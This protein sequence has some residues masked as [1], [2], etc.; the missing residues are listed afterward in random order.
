MTT[1]IKNQTFIIV[2]QTVLRGFRQCSCS[3]CEENTVMPLQQPVLV[4]VQNCT[5]GCMHPFPLPYVRLCL[6]IRLD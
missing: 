1:A 4:G 2:M 3:Q 6:H 5:A